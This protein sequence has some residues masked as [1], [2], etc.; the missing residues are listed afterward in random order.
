MARQSPFIWYHLDSRVI[1]HRISASSAST[2]NHCADEVFLLYIMKQLQNSTRIDIVWYTYV[3]LLAFMRTCCMPVMC[4][5]QSW[6]YIGTV[7][8]F[9]Y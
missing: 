5:K 6:V 2:L 4:E 3:E 1:G 7:G 8:V 9:C